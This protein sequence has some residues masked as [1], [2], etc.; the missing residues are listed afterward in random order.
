MKKENFLNNT[1]IY[2]ANTPAIKVY[3]IISGEVEVNN[4]ILIK[5]YA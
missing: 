3:F 5:I 2:S 4:P 1:K